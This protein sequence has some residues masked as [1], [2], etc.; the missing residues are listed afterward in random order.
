MNTIR[1]ILTDAQSE[2]LRAIPHDG[3]VFFCAGR[4]SW[5]NGDCIALHL[6]PCKSMAELNKAADVARGVLGTR[7]KSTTATAST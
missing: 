7:K 6:I 4:A 3:P 5:P 1:L 2:M